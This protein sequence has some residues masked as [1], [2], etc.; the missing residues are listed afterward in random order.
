MFS[1]CVYL[2]MEDDYWF[3][4]DPGVSQTELWGSN[5]F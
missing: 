2:Q 1:H 3:Q 4:S 5:I